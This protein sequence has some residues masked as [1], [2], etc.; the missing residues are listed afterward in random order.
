MSPHGHAAMVA[1]RREQPHLAA[2]YLEAM[3]LDA[4]ELAGASPSDRDMGPPWNLDVIRALLAQMSGDLEL[5]YA[6]RLRWLAQPFV[7]KAEWYHQ[8]P[9]LMSSALEMSDAETVS[10]VLKMCDEA[11]PNVPWRLTVRCCRALVAEDPAE[12]IE[13][14]ADLRRYGWNLMFVHAAEEAAVMLARAGEVVAA[15]SAFT[16]AMSVYDDLGATWDLRRLAAR[17]RPFGIRRGSRTSSRRAL[18]GWPSLT[19]AEQRVA[20]LAAQGLSNPDI[21]RQLYLSRNTVQF[22]VS[23]IL[24]KLS[25][26][27]RIEL[28]D[29]VPPA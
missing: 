10:K 19:P 6:W 29:V 28:R 3:G 16:D 26:H 17:L 11:T 12:L 21:A 2:Q 13:V 25:L 8:L 1:L 24:S 18:I 15:R 27:S 7:L 9:V 5:A 23:T 14:A 4:A 22:Y 20:V